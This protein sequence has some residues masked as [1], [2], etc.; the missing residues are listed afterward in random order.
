MQG[1]SGTGL[2]LVIAGPR[3]S[4]SSSKIMDRFLRLLGLGRDPIRTV[5]QD[6]PTWE[7]LQL[8]MPEFSAAS[9]EHPERLFPGATNYCQLELLPPALIRYIASWLS[10]S[11][12]VSLSLC[13]HWLLDLL[14]KKSLQDLD[15]SAS[16]QNERAILLQALGRD[17][18][19]TLYCFACNRLHVLFKRDEVGLGLEQLFR[20]VADGRCS[21]GDGT[22]NYGTSLTYHPD[23]RFEHIQMATK[24]RRRGYVSDAKAYL[25]LLSFLQ[26]ARGL[27][28]YSPHT[29]GLYFFE[30]RFVDGQVFVRAQSW[31]LIPITQGSKVPMLH[32]TIVCHHLDGNGIHDGRVSSD[33]AHV[34]AFRCKLKHLVRRQDSCEKCHSLIRCHYCPTEINVELRRPN[35][36]AECGLLIITKWQVLG[37]GLSPLE[38][39]WESHLETE[40][41]IAPWPYPPDC[42]P[43]FIRDV[44][45]NQH[46]IEHGS[47]I[48]VEKAWQ[49]LNE[50]EIIRTLDQ[51]PFWD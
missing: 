15:K 11:S 33:N 47:L 38:A 13:S 32:H 39:H 37:R 30:P 24:L 35:G 51:I 5:S 18:P 19:G 34:M 46:G 49:L 50:S 26:P 42:A 3:L 44:Y 29:I 12:A 9:S 20:R 2:E 36:N 31:I 48:E 8:L 41:H 14:G 1:R 25:T 4:S 17:L 21:L 43:G 6:A 23:F 10:L 27:I 28:T 16:C 22:Y 40:K 45:E 7:Q